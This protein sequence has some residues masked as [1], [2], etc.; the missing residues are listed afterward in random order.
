MV[1]NIFSPKNKKPGF[2]AYEFHGSFQTKSKLCRPIVPASVMLKATSNSYQ[3][4]KIIKLEKREK[5]ML[6]F[7]IFEEKKILKFKSLF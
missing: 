4:A 5:K 3:G 2:T 7:I 1:Y 6:T